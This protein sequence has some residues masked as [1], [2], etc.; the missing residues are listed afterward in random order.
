MLKTVDL[1][2]RKIT[3]PVRKTGEARERQLNEIGL[4]IPLEILGNLG[5]IPMYKDVRKAVLENIYKDLRK[6][7]AEAE[8]TKRIKEEMLQGFDSESDMKRYDYELWSN[9]FGPNSPGYDAREAKKKLKAAER[10]VKKQLK[11]ELHDYTPKV[12]GKSTGFGR[13]ERKSS[14]FG[15]SNKKSSGFGRSNKKS[16]GFG[17]RK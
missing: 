4:R 13:S 6:A 3:E 16:S 2:I 7:L 17:R 9:T 10:K 11:D 5:M 8:D 12:K 1:I 15:R 14:G